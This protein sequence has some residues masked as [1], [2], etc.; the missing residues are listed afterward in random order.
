MDS[1]W[2]LAAR[3]SLAQQKGTRFR[4]KMLQNGIEWSVHLAP[5]FCSP[6]E[7]L[8]VRSNGWTERRANESAVGTWNKPLV[9]N[10]GV[11]RA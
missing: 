5:P 9:D 6:F 8:P 3:R 10:P 1:E 4:L 2:N 11:R 7:P